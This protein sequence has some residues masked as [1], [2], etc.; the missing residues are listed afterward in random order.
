[1]D[2][3]KIL[4]IFWKILG[5]FFGRNFLGEILWEEFFGNSL[6]TFWEFF[7]KCHW[8]LTFSKANWFLTFSK[9]VD[10][11]HFQ[12]Q[13]IVY[14][15]NISYLHMEEIDLFV[16][17]LS[18]CT[19]KE[20]RKKFRSLEVQEAS[21][22]PDKEKSFLIPRCKIAVKNI[23]IFY[24]YFCELINLYKMLPGKV[25]FL[26]RQQFEWLTQLCPKS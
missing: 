13:L 5:E 18:Q 21:M 15:L 17:I 23:Y 9:S 10:C 3:F 12:S 26:A 6:G 22:W 11:L 20:G 1:M 4:G 7:G 19:R 14:I 2:I 24:S 25:L 16:K 8:L